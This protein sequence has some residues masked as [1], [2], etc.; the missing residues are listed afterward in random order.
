MSDAYIYK[1][2]E[3][4]MLTNLVQVAQ[5]SQETDE[6]WTTLSTLSRLAQGATETDWVKKI[7]TPLRALFRKYPTDWFLQTAKQYMDKGETPETKRVV[8]AFLIELEVPSSEVDRVLHDIAGCL[9]DSKHIPT[10]IS[11]PR[12]QPVQQT[13][14]QRAPAHVQASAVHHPQPQQPQYQ[15]PSPVNVGSKMPSVPPE[16]LPTI[17]DLPDE[18]IERPLAGYSP[19]TYDRNAPQM[20]PSKYG[21][22]TGVP[23]KMG[24]G[25]SNIASEK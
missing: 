11:A 1:L 24:R 13:A 9:A 3:A 4:L 21:H 17:V 25:A 19:H 6:G 10:A 15:R 20:K 22:I 5:R 14:P 16:E 23:Y 2:S 8:F 12:S 18:V 7:V